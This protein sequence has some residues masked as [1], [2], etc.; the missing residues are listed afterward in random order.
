MKESKN[1]KN[2]TKISE[3]EDERERQ[4]ERENER[5]LNAAMWNSPLCIRQLGGELND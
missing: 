1:R 4:R 5:V 2:V 3:E